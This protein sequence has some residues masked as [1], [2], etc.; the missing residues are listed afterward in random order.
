MKKVSEL[1][2]LC[3]VDACAVIYG[4]PDAQPDVCP[5]PPETYH[6]L[7]RFC[8]LP[9]MKKDLSVM[10][11]ETFLTQNVTR[12]NTTLQKFKYRNWRVEKEQLMGKNLVE[13]NLNDVGNLKDLEDVS[14]LLEGRINS[15]AKQIEHIKSG[16]VRGN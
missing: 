12:V 6:V 15:A 1:R 2:T 7:E 14:G 9:I 11:R 4:T 10:N 3:G 8:N 13:I 16:G 5:S